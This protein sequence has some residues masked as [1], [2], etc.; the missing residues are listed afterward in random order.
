MLYI[1]FKNLMAELVISGSWLGTLFIVCFAIPGVLAVLTSLQNYFLATGWIGKQ[2][3]KQSQR[4]GKT[5]Q[6]HKENIPK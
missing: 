6:N 5:E 3:Q 2:Q 1:G 4:L